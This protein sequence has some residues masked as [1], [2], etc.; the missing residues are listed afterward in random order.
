MKSIDGNDSEIYYF[1]SAFYVLCNDKWFGRLQVDFCTLYSS[2][3]KE[4]EFK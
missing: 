2:G 3:H 1:D 4:L